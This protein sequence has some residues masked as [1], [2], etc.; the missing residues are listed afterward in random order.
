MYRKH[1][2]KWS[3]QFWLK[4]KKGLVTLTRMPFS[5]DWSAL[6]LSGQDTISWFDSE[7]NQLWQMFGYKLEHV[8]GFYFQRPI[9]IY[10]SIEDKGLFLS[11][12]IKV[13]LLYYSTAYN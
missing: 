13:K 11:K 2:N 10:N 1:W 7:L 9:T 12:T 6:I 3:C 5:I 4:G 8:M